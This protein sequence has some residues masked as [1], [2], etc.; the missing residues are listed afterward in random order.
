MPINKSKYRSV[1]LLLNV[2]HL[3]GDDIS[4]KMKTDYKHEWNYCS[5]PIIERLSTD[6]SMLT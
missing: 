5:G 1:L 6:R 4:G 3:D 2:T